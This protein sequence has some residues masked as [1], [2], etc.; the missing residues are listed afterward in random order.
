M[1]GGVLQP[2]MPLLASGRADFSRYGIMFLF[3]FLVAFYCHN[4]TSRLIL[5]II[6]GLWR[7]GGVSSTVTTVT[8]VTVVTVRH[9]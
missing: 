5:L 2:G 1:I 8:R 4:V 9:T 6:I 3:F 7:D